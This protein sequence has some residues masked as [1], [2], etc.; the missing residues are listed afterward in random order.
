[1]ENAAQSLLHSIGYPPGGPNVA[2]R[3]PSPPAAPIFGW[4]LDSNGDDDFDI[5]PTAAEQEI[6]EA[7]ALAR[8]L[9]ELILRVDSDDDSECELSDEEGGEFQGVGSSDDSDEEGQGKFRAIYFIMY[10]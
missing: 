9:E 2:H 1:V 8:E 3:S 6:E 5:A 10:L 7:R 4:N